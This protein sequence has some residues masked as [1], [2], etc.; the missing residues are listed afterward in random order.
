MES[1]FIGW[2]LELWDTNY[3]FRH[4]HY[5]GLWYWTDKTPIFFY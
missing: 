4:Y 1:G 2:K 3:F 5:S